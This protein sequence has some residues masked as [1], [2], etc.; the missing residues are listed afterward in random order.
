LTGGVVDNNLKFRENKKTEVGLK[1]R[2][3]T[4]ANIRTS[5]LFQRDERNDFIYTEINTVGTSFVSLIGRVTG[6]LKG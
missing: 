4:M 5:T 1:Q 2:F 3:S 6:L